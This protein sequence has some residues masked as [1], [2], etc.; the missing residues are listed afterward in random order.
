MKT[1]TLRQ[2]ALGALLVALGCST[3]GQGFFY[4]GSGVGL[5]DFKARYDKRGDVDLFPS[6]SLSDLVFSDRD[7]GDGTPYS[8]SA[9]AGFR[10]EL[11]T[12]GLWFGVQAETVF[13][14]DVIEGRLAGVGNT[15]DG[16]T[17][18]NLFEED[19]TLQ[20]DRDRSL[21]LRTGTV[22]SFLGIFDFSPYVVAGIREVE[23]EFERTFEICDALRLCQP[24]EQGTLTT[25]RR[26]P[27]L[28]Q[29][30]LGIGIEK[31]IGEK[32]SISFEARYSS[33]DDDEWEDLTNDVIVP[34]SL[35]ADSYDISL[36]FSVYL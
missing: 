33:E 15:V 3:H 13:K 30:I 5:E 36:K 20:T 18:Q 24:M 4:V 34:A 16:L 27:S 29:M 23:V 35:S 6:L 1:N 10:F 25:D 11:H 9:F 28:L 8:L 22:F 32:I 21:V 31:F 7:G 14:S 12:K 17:V 2:F 26:I 19:W